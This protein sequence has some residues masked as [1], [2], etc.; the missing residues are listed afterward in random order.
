MKR[1]KQDADHLIKE[2]QEVSGTIKEMDDK[3]REVR[4]NWMSSC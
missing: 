1:E 4:K 2:M 3:V